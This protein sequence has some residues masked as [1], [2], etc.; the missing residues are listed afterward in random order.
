MRPRPTIVALPYITGATTHACP[1]HS[2]SSSLVTDDAKEKAT[3][4]CADGKLDRSSEKN[5]LPNVKSLGVL[6]CVTYGRDRPSA[7]FNNPAT[8]PPP[9]PPPP[10]R[11]PP[12]PPPAPRPPPPLPPTPPPLTPPPP[13]TP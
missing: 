10:P 5:P 6:S 8:P 4:V 1:G 3:A 11:P 12:P 9:P 2:R 7:P 13:H